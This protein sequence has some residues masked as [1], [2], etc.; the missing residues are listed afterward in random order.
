[1]KKPENHGG[2]LLELRIDWSELDLFG[3]VNNVMF[4]KYIQAGRVNFWEKMG[5]Y[6]SLQENGMGPILASSKCDFRKPLFYPG[7]VR[8]YSQL[9]FM[10]T[11]SFGFQHMLLDDSGDLVAE[12]H[13]VV[14]MYDF[15]KKSK[16]QIPDVFRKAA[17]ALS[18]SA[19]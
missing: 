10:R 14:V 11:T 5:L 9:E 15:S 16:V 18:G 4:F 13:D 8:I 3:H 1:M 7:N 6:K 19:P 2:L 12:A 17:E